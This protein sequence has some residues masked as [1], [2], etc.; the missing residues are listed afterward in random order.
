MVVGVEVE[1]GRIPVQDA[2]EGILETIEA[3]ARDISASVG[4]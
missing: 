1:P 2:S 3:R 4:N